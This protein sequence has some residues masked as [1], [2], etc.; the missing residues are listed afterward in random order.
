MEKLLLSLSFILT[1]M[2]GSY[3]WAAEDITTGKDPVNVSMSRDYSIP[4]TEK[5]KQGSAKIVETGNNSTKLAQQV[6]G[7]FM[8]VGFASQCCHGP[9]GYYCAPGC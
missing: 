2:I 6:C 1:L 7:Q 4:M 8:C 3:A 5:T 9:S